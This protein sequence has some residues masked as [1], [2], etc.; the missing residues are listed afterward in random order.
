MKTGMSLR[1]ICNF[2]Y[3]LTLEL[4]LVSPL[5]PIQII[6]GKTAP[7]LVLSIVNAA[8]IVV[9]GVFVFGIPMR[10]SLLLLAGMALFF[11]VLSLRNFKD[12]LA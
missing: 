3:L 1:S 6:P 10:G 2:A 8:V 12:R 7:C 4:L 11:L 5:R 9:L